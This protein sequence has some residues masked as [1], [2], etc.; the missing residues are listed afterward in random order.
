MTTPPNGFGPTGFSPNGRARNGFAGNDGGRT[1]Y[2]SSHRTREY[3]FHVNGN[4]NGN[5]GRSG[6]RGSSGFSRRGAG[7]QGMHSPLADPEFFNNVDIRNY[8]EAGR[9]VFLQLSFELAAAAEVLQAVLKEVPDPEGRPFGSRARARRVAKRLTKA[10]EDARDTAKNMAATY[11]AFQREYDPE[12]APYRSRQR[13]T[14][15]RFDFNG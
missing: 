11:A 3:H 2:R 7:R 13:P 15:R 4:G 5:G 14:S 8:C 12:L 9:S 6:D 1:S 10:A